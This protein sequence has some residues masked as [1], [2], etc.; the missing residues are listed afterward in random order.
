MNR[1]MQNRLS[2][3]DISDLVEMLLYSKY[4]IQ[5]GKAFNSIVSALTDLN[6]WHIFVLCDSSGIRFLYYN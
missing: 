1:S 3:V 6:R 5:L 4:Y 2:R